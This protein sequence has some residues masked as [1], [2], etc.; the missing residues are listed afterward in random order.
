[1]S[2]PRKPR[3]QRRAESR[4]DAK[5]VRDRER[6]AALE[7]GG[8]PER[9]IEVVSA[10]LVEPKARAMPCPVCGASVRVEDHT[11]RTLQGAP[12]RMAHVVCPMCRHAR[13]VYFSI[14]PPLQN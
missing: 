9:P 6:L 7:A 1:V 14:R 5:V 11:A 12:R 10:S 3:A 13:V 4:R 2:P 8:T